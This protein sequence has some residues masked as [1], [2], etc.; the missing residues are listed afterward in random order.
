MEDSEK[1]DG[2]RAAKVV[3]VQESRNPG[4]WQSRLESGEKDE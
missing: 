4:T 1:G 2:G 3:F